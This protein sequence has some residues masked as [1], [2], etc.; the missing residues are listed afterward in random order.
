MEVIGG[1]ATVDCDKGKQFR[2]I[3]LG[4]LVESVRDSREHY[5]RMH[6]A[7]GRRD[8]YYEMYV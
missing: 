7:F 4:F 3:A 8:T 1:V 5:Y 2:K 6:R